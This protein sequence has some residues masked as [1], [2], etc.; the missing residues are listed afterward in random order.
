M[1]RV[2]CDGCR[3]EEALTVHGLAPDGWFRV[4]ERGN[5]K[6]GDKDYCSLACAVKGL[7]GTVPA[8]QPAA[9]DAHRAAVGVL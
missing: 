8:K 5:Y 3:K 2:I 4:H 1:T 9:S 6:D 7:S